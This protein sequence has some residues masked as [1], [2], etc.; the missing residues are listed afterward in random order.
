MSSKIIYN[1]SSPL[2]PRGN[3]LPLLLDL[4]RTTLFLH[5]ASVKSLDELLNPKRGKKSPHLY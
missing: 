4:A 2:L 3:A 5:D 1:H